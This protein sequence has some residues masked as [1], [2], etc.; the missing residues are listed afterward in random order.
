MNE[1][2]NYKWKVCIRCFTFNH[3]HYITDALNGFTMQQTTFP[4]VCAIVDDASTDGE[5]DVI[6]KYLEENFELNNKDIVRTEETDDYYLIFAQHKTNRNCYFVVLF[7]KYNHYRKKSKFPYLSE[8]NDNTEYRAVC[9][10]DDY[11]TDA[12]KL[13][14][15]ATFLDNH[16]E[17]T[18][19]FC[20][21]QMISKNGTIQ[22]YTIPKKDAF[23]ENCIVSLADLFR[24]EFYRG[25]WC[26]HLLSFMYKAET[27]I[28]SDEMQSFFKKFPYGDMPLEI[29]CLIH[30]KGFFINDICGCYRLLS[31]GY[32]SYV[33]SHP[34]YGIAQEEKL[35]S[36]LSYL[37]D[38]T[39]RKYH[40]EISMRI[41]RGE[42]KIEERFKG[43]KYAVYRPRFWRLAIKMRITKHIS[44][45]LSFFF[46][47]LHHYI[48]S[49]ITKSQ[50]KT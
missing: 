41:L 50:A 11:W 22:Y 43:H 10:G 36:A 26:F 23:I 45:F 1:Q 49:V 14:K 8:W 44:A 34:E 17:C 2:P 20:K 27:C 42:L 24:E 21:V 28:N 32:N 48:I 6:K 25:N 29:W 13:Q 15:Q 35:I 38:M 5:Q 16:H 9:E 40:K 30:G 37:D 4:F 12:H 7:L 39:S 47:K 3:A 46:P 19:C 31:G 33:Y 18:I